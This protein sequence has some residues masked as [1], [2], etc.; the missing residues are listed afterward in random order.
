MWR[1][2]T[3]DENRDGNDRFGKRGAAVVAGLHPGVPQ[4]LVH[5]EDRAVAVSEY[6]RALDQ[7]LVNW[8]GG[9]IGARCETVSSRNLLT[10]LHTRLLTTFDDMT[11]V[12][13]QDDGP[14]DCCRS[15][16]E[17]IEMLETRRGPSGADRIG[18]IEGVIDVIE[19]TGNDGAVLCVFDS[20]TDVLCK[21]VAAR[22]CFEISF[23]E[24]HLTRTAQC[25]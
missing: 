19:D 3:V 21:R 9:C 7:D 23:V 17:C 2:G 4:L 12:A 10:A 22:D 1:Y 15:R 25:V 14:T 24:E 16:Q 11:V 5:R 8:H 6:T 18:P 13:D 20:G